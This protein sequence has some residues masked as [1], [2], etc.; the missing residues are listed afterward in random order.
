[1]SEDTSVAAGTTAGQ[2]GADT[3]SAGTQ[4]RRAREAAGLHVAA[5]AVAM[6]VPVKKLEALEADR[7]DQLPDAVFVRALA[8]SVCRTL[9]IDPASV[10]R[11]L[12]Q[13]STPRLD[14]ED[15][16]IN[17]PFRAGGQG[18]AHTVRSFVAKPTVILVGVLLLAALGI[19]L[20]PEI[21]FST[22]A[23]SAA[24]EHAAVVVVPLAADPVALGASAAA[25]ESVLPAAVAASAAVVASYTSLTSASAALAAPQAAPATAAASRAAAAVSAAVP[26]PGAS[27]AASAVGGVALALHAKSETWVSVTDANK[28]SLIRRAMVAGE[29]VT[30]SGTLPLFVVIGRADAVTMD[31]RG[32]PV[33]ITPVAGSNVAR[34]EVK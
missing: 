5:L 21:H 4:L 22:P 15:R 14:T 10:L 6:K 13:Q 11:K 31:V 7:W 8:S 25:A 3:G 30:L 34:F 23:P 20:M 27:A 24:Q 26:A 28:Q 17:A 9:K 29:S 18:S 32:K 16:A 19:V 33:A 12:P 2:S 1:M